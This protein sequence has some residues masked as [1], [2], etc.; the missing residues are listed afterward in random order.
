MKMA[1][2]GSRMATAGAT[3]IGGGPH[4]ECARPRRM[5]WPKSSLGGYNGKWNLSPMAVRAW[6]YLRGW[7]GHG[8]NTWTCLCDCVPGDRKAVLP[9]VGTKKRL[10]PR[11]VRRI[12]DELGLEWNE[13]P[14]MA[15]RSRSSSALGERTASGLRRVNMMKVSMAMFLF[16]SRHL[17]STLANSC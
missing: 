4:D 3:T 6:L 16:S 2:A 14:S 13:L 5:N 12:V 8:W 7:Q 17:S 1:T 15:W 10:D 9:E 11:I